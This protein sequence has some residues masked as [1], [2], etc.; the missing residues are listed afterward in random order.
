[1]ILSRLGLH[2][3]RDG[4][5]WRCVESP[6]LRMTRDGTYHVDGHVQVFVSLKEVAQHLTGPAASQDIS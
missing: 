5:R 4:D 3:T 2:F 6:G 1:M